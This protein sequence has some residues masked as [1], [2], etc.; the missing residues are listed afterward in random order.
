MTNTDTPLP[1]YYCTT[2]F[3]TSLPI[4]LTCGRSERGEF[5]ATCLKC[6]DHNHG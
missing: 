5:T 4:G 1:T 2:C 3:S 6:C